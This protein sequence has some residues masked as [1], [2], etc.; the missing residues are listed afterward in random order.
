VTPA[1]PVQ[2]KAI[3]LVVVAVLPKSLLSLG[4]RL[5]LVAG[6]LATSDERWQPVDMAAT[7]IAA[8]LVR[9]LRVLLV[10]WIWLRLRRQ[11]RLRLARAEGCH[12]GIRAGLLA[13]ILV[14]VVVEGF[15]PS[16]VIRTRKVRVVLAELFLRRGDQSEI[17]LGV[18]IVIF[19]RYRIARRVSVAGQLNV[20]LGDVRRGSANFYVGAVR[21]ENP[22]HWILIFAVVVVIVVIP[23]AHALI[24]LNV[25]HGLPVC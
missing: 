6:L 9:P 20:F 22:R 18:L 4:L 16:V 19:R 2:R 3:G 7:L 11:K 1:P 14:A 5:R 12:S 15:V 17:V 8:L 24:V 13:E 23:P 25:S 21:L 10:L